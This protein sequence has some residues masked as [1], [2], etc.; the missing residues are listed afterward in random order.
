MPRVRLPS[1]HTL[2]YLRYT[3]H[4][5]PINRTS[6]SSTTSPYL[7]RYPSTGYRILRQWQKFS[8]ETKFAS[9]RIAV[10]SQCRCWYHRR[11]DVAIYDYSHCGPYR[12]SFGTCP[13]PTLAPLLLLSLN[14]NCSLLLQYSWK[15][16]LVGMACIPLLFFSGYV[17]L[18]VVE[19]KDAK[20]EAVHSEA[21][22]KACEA[23]A[24]IR[25]VATLSAERSLCAEYS[26]AL[27]KAQLIISHNVRHSG[28][29]ANLLVT[30]K[31]PIASQP[32]P[33]S[34][35]T[36]FSAQLSLS[37]SSSLLLSSGMDHDNS[38]MVRST[39]PT[40]LLP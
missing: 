10:K 38:S 35:Q 24:S 26:Q 32:E 37:I 8:R 22:Q 5:F 21:A 29:S 18:R 15:I 25:T 13:F 39:L 1:L 19:Q 12:R 34:M 7:R 30:Q 2:W 20:V 27:G 36:C 28:T 3:D 11:C 14:I 9:Q 31:L 33:Q 40:S 23:A 17:R 16:S 6:I 4:D